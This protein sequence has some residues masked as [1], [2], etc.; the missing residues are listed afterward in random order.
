MFLFFAKEEKEKILNFLSLG[1]YSLFQVQVHPRPKVY[2]F[3]PPFK[4][5]LSLAN[6][7]R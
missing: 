2:T 4:F 1:M 5:F 6:R 3:A 7:C